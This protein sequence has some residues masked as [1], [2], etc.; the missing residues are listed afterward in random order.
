MGRE[1]RFGK[2]NYIVRRLDNF[3]ET[4]KKWKQDILECSFI[5]KQINKQ[6]KG[7]A[8][9]TRKQQQLKGNAVGWQM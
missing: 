3:G 9:A 6:A 5:I 7:L 1:T 8:E 2:K 4:E